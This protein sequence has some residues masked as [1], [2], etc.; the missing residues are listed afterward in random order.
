MKLAIRS[1]NLR[2]TDDTRATIERRIRFAIGRFTPRIRSVRVVVRDMNGPKGGVDKSCTIE[3]VVDRVGP[4]IATGEYADLM[5][6]VDVACHRIDRLVSREL[7]RLRPTSDEKAL[8]RE[9]ARLA[10]AKG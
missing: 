2:M 4:L 1:R 8:G 3:C 6:A 10:E 7:S 9:L 5:T